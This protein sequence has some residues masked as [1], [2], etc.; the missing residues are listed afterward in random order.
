ML[1]ACFW[2]R[3]WAS[4][5]RDLGCAAGSAGC[6]QMHKRCNDHLARSRKQ[7]VHTIEQ[8]RTGDTESACTDCRTRVGDLPTA[9]LEWVN[10]RTLVGDL[11]MN[12]GNVHKQNNMCQECS[13]KNQHDAQF[14]IFQKSTI[15]HNKRC[16]D[17]LFYL[18]DVT[19]F[20][21]M[22]I[23]VNLIILL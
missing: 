4:G 7:N 5:A 8:S 11:R 6:V 14:D 15:S 19:E 13:Y 16:Y 10:C 17:C 3:W 18:P 9:N 23:C 21:F 12:A 1:L 2:L 22:R 20:C